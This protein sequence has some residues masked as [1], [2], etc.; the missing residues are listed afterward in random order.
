MTLTEKLTKARAAI[1]AMRSLR[2]FHTLGGATAE[3]ISRSLLVHGHVWHLMSVVAMTLQSTG[4]TS[5][6]FSGSHRLGASQL[7]LQV[8][9]STRFGNDSEMTLSRDVKSIFELSSGGHSVPVPASRVN[10][11]TDVKRFLWQRRF[12]RLS[13]LRVLQHK[14]SCPYRPSHVKLVELRKK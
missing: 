12:I 11:Q 2:L 14:K 4:R 6:V 8:F 9:R 7:C 3:M 10:G 1:S 5:R 13:A